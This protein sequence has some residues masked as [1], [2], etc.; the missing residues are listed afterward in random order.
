MRKVVGKTKLTFEEAGTITAMIEACLNSRT[1]SALSPGEEDVAALTPGHFLIGAPLTSPA[2]PFIDI[3]ENCS[4]TSRCH[5]LSLMRNHFLRRWQ[6][7]FLSQVQQRS[8]WLHPNRGFKEDDVVLFKDALNPPTKWPLARIM[9]LHHGTDGLCRVSTIK[10]GDSTYK[11]AINKLIL[12]PVNQET[13]QHHAQKQAV[14]AGGRWVFSDFNLLVLSEERRE[15]F[16]NC[17]L[18]RTAFYCKFY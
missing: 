15:K 16:V 7:E 12:L 17:V 14:T 11:R 10:S 4:L 9:Q 1:L 13:E 18:L 5:L 3:N 8:K 6:R 2:E